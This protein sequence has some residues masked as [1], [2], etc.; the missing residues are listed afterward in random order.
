MF[1]EVAE[2]LLT[3]AVQGVKNPP[4]RQVIFPGSDTVWDCELV[5]VRLVGAD[6]V[7]G[8]QRCPAYLDVTF[9]VGTVRCVTGPTRQGRAPTKEQIT[10]DG[11]NFMADAEDLFKALACLTIEHPRVVWNE[12]GSITPMGP[13]GNMASVEW[14]MV[15][16]MT[17]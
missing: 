7:A 17:R 15:V 11:L 16:R 12:I 13:I 3:T 14:R 9:G 2:L 6:P 1:A 5:Y 4:E 10:S 8:N